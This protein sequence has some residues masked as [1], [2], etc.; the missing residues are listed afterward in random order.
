MLVF[1]SYRGMPC[2]DHVD[3]GLL[4]II[5]QSG[6]QGLEVFEP[7]TLDEASRDGDSG[8]ASGDG[9]NS[10]GDGGGA[11]GDSGDAGTASK[12]G[13]RWIAPGNLE[14]PDGSLVFLAGSML[15]KITGGRVYA[16]RH[17]VLGADDEG[18]TP[19]RISIVY[20]M[21]PP[22][23]TVL[24]AA[25]AAEVEGEGG[26]DGIEGGAGELVSSRRGKRG[27]GR[28]KARLT[29]RDF[30]RRF[31]DLHVSVNEQ[32]PP[33]GDGGGETKSSGGDAG[34]PGEALHGSDSPGA[35]GGGISS[36]GSKA[37]AT[38]TTTTTATSSKGG[39]ASPSPRF[40]FGS[41]SS[42]TSSPFS[43]GTFAFGAASPS[44][45]TAT[46]PSVGFKFGIKA[47]SQKT[48][49]GFKFTPGLSPTE[50]PGNAAAETFSFAAATA[51]SLSTPVSSSPSFLA[52]KNSAVSA[53]SASAS[54]ASPVFKFTS[55]TE[56]KEDSDGRH[57][58]E[59]GVPVG[60]GDG[61]GEGGFEAAIEI[62]KAEAKAAGEERLERLRLHQ[63]GGDRSHLPHPMGGVG[64][65]NAE[66]MTWGRDDDDDN[67]DEDDSDDSDDQEEEYSGE[68]EE[69]STSSS[70]A[71]HS[72][73]GYDSEN[74]DR[75]TDDDQRQQIIDASG[76]VVQVI[77][78]ADHVAPPAPTIEGVWALRLQLSTRHNPPQTLLE[79]SMLSLLEL[80]LPPPRD[81][82]DRSAAARMLALLPSNIGAQLIRVVLDR[83]LLAVL[84]ITGS[85]PSKD[86]IETRLYFEIDLDSEEINEAVS[87]SS[88]PCGSEEK[89][90]VSKIMQGDDPHY[91][92][93]GSLHIPLVA[94]VECA[95]FLATHV[96]QSLSETL[97][98]SMIRTTMGYES[99]QA[100]IHRR[101][102]YGRGQ[103]GRKASCGPP[104][105]RHPAAHHSYSS[106][107]LAVQA[108]A[109]VDTALLAQFLQ[110]EQAGDGRG[111]SG[112]MSTPPVLLQVVKLAHT[113]LSSL[114]V[115]AAAFRHVTTLDLAGTAINAGDLGMC[116]GFMP[117]LVDLD[118]HG[119]KA[120]LPPGLQLLAEGQSVRLVRL[121]VSCYDGKLDYNGLGRL[122]SLTQ[123]DLRPKPCNHILRGRIDARVGSAFENEWGH[124]LENSGEM[125]GSSLVTALRTMSMLLALNAPSVV[126][127]T[128]TAAV[129]PWEDPPPAPS[130]VL[131]IKMC[132]SLTSLDAS[133]SYAVRSTTNLRGEYRSVRLGI[134]LVV[135]SSSNK[136]SK[137]MLSSLTSLNLSWRNLLD[138]EFQALQ[139]G[140]NLLA[141]RHLNL[142]RT[143]VTSP[144]FIDHLPSIETIDLQNCSGISAQFVKGLKASVQSRLARVGTA[145]GGIRGGLGGSSG[146]GGDDGENGDRE[147]KWGGGDR[148][149]A[150]HLRSINMRGCAVFIRNEEDRQESGYVVEPRWTMRDAE[151]EN[152]VPRIGLLEHLQ[153][154]FCPLYFGTF[155][156]V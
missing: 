100:L 1:F 112:G 49:P 16:C 53:L 54:S 134:P 30:L 75:K 155:S 23:A 20:K 64:R 37:A 150:N 122:T 66:Q 27:G 59:W 35:E 73:E 149:E 145:G 39:S 18:G 47:S 142:S 123:L 151:L 148:A 146:G 7:G 31:A 65:R 82:E 89:A 12:A 128:H 42:T 10:G 139:G 99:R 70:A 61:F 77:V 3:K 126:M 129:R 4:T 46:A 104:W 26:V 60:E 51:A 38:T 29:V 131:A 154:R 72:S 76:N 97:D 90:F 58:G 96:D 118:I 6:G 87:S 137:H 24:T 34:A 92:P 14:A 95:Q 119:T 98:L 67:D 111:G 48:S 117:A 21:V 25:A 56:T 88:S 141:L 136:R 74:D 135:G 68:G 91:D 50:S 93:R 80:V 32:K 85:D 120:V 140:M 101:K 11:G 19:N 110:R 44:P 43:A 2:P 108:Q 71:N 94:L 132:P 55:P 143:N 84:G 113:C 147:T 130:P 22:A 57:K 152:V 45:K 116:A 69:Y 81:P 156:D 83:R 107:D 153:V 5:D 103:S 63:P 125:S 62:A 127:Q 106:F 109:T 52:N 105:D 13:G 15:S 79:R 114:W 8:K 40:T 138:G 121:C 9:G 86:P 33:S 124:R 144:E 41:P 102:A 78:D 36:S 115:G 28:E 133:S 17:R